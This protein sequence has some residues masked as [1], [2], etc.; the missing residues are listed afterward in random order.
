MTVHVVMTGRIG[1]D[2]TRCGD[3]RQRLSA[4]HTPRRLPRG[5]ADGDWLSV[6]HSTT[7]T[8]YAHSRP[9]ITLEKHVL[10]VTCLIALVTLCALHMR[11]AQAGHGLPWADVMVGA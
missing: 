5:R 6:G 11:C 9:Q 7:S 10:T 3:H 2:R 8:G 4:R 1:L